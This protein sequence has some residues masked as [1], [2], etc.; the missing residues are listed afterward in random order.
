[1]I[2]DPY[3]FRDFSKRTH[4]IEFYEWLPEGKSV[5]WL[6]SRTR[7]I[8]I[9]AAHIEMTL[10]CMVPTQLAA[11]PHPNAAPTTLDRCGRQLTLVLTSVSLSLELLVIKVESHSCG[12][13]WG[14]QSTSPTTSAWCQWMGNAR[15]IYDNGRIEQYTIYLMTNYN[16]NTA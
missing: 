12:P 9:P 4:C 2:I 16:D 5:K 10:V 6:A 7:F 15:P 3:A 1:M 13:S 14:N 8:R 11:G